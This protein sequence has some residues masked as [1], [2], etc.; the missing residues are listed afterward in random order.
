[1]RVRK[2]KSV[3]AYDDKWI[4]EYCVRAVI[5]SDCSS[6]YELRTYSYII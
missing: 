5:D 2:V 4:D 1:M 3:E 6:S